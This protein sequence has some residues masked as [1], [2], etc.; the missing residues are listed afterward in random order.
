M[1]EAHETLL[2]IDLGALAHNYKTLRAKIPQDVKFMAVVKAYAYGN[3]SVE[4]AKKLQGRR[5]FWLILTK[6]KD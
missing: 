2:E 6:V 1:P 5:L 4:M 3:D